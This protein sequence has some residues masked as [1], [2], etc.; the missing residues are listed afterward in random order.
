MVSYLR[1]KAVGSHDAAGP[2]EVPTSSY[3]MLDAGLRRRLWHNLDVVAT[4]R[5]LLNESYQSSAGPRWVWA[6]GRHGSVTLV[7]AF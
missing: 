7:V 1:I 3:T 6:A 5:N 4:M 2:T